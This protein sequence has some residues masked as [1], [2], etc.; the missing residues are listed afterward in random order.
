MT[1]VADILEEEAE[2]LKSLLKNREDK[3]SAY[4]N[5]SIRIRNIQ[6]H[7]YLYRVYRISTKVVSKYLCKIENP[8]AEKY[9]KENAVRKELKNSIK[10]IR[11]DL[12]LIGKSLGKI[13]DK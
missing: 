5:G 11:Q 13:R 2:R 10:E 12:Y 6:G 8:L 1:I 9:L 3:L 4:P 7:K